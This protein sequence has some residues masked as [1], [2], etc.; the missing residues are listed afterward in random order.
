MPRSMNNITRLWMRL[1]KREKFLASLAVMAALSWVVY[2]YPYTMQERQV[3]LL[4]AKADAVEKDILDVT[5]QIAELRA[6]AE[7]ARSGEGMKGVAGL[8][9]VDQKGVVLFLQDVSTEAR[10]LGVDLVAVHPTKEIDKEKYREISVNLDLK[11]RYRELSEYF[12]R[13][14]SLSRVVNVRKIRVE[15]CPDASSVCAVQLEAVT[16]MQK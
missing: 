3:K 10:R 9:L 1:S 16:Y 8:D 5:A 11:G 4:K 14:E 13:L 15:A 6:R 2:Q 12:R 7:Q